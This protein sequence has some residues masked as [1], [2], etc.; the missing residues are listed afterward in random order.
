MVSLRWTRSFT[1][2]CLAD[3]SGAA[4]VTAIIYLARSLG[5]SSIAEGVKKEDQ[6][7]FLL[8]QGCDEVQGYLMGRPMFDWAIACFLARQADDDDGAVPF[9]SGHG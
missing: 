9:L 4:I 2:T 8:Q 1:A 5:I 7:L 6:R 3:P